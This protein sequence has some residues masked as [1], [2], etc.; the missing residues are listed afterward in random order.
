MRMFS[1]VKKKKVVVVLE[2]KNRNCKS[3]EDKAGFTGA[4]GVH[5]VHSIVTLYHIY[6]PCL[7]VL[8]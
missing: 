7:F 1:F 3:G 6:F 2:R 5:A 8:S 4:G